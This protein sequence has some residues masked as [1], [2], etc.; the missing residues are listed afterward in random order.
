MKDFL[1]LS[2]GFNALN[3]TQNGYNPR[4]QQTQ[5]QLPTYTAQIIYST[6]HLQ[7]VVST[8]TIRIF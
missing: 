7:D 5:S 1:Y 3:Q 4:C 2:G 8:K 6:A